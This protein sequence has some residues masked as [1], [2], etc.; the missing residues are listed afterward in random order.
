MSMP[1]PRT[2]WPGTTRPAIHPSDGNGPVADPADRDRAAARAL[3]YADRGWPVFPCR[4]GSKEPATRHGFHDATTDPGQIRAW[5]QRWPD[6]NLAIATGAPGPDV[7]DVDHHGHAGHGYTALMRLKTAGLLDNSG[8]IVRTPHGG[9][10]VYFTGSTQPSGRLPG[11]HLDFKA[12]GGYILAPPS[13]VDGRPYYLVR[14]IEPSGELSWAEVTGILGLQ[15][16]R[17]VRQAVDSGGDVSRLPAWVE[18]LEEGNRNAGLFW[19]ACWAVE[20]GQPS[21]LDDIAAAAVKTGLSEREITRTIDSAR[22]G[23][24]RSVSPRP[25]REATR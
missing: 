4:P 3:A 22:R 10:H 15:R 11:H 17:T 24:Q 25:D 23:G 6:A 16:D 9:L 18:R 8:T 14:Q 12:A 20:S 13:Q 7:L 1:V 21:V 2:R 19:A 5:W